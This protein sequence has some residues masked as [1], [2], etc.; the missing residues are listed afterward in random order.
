MASTR[1]IETQHQLLGLLLATILGVQKE[2]D[3]DDGD[4]L[5]VT[6]PKN[7]KQLLNTESIEQLLCQFV[8]WHSSR[9]FNDQCY[10]EQD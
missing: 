5:R 2:D 10:R 1:S 8:A 3:N 4:D 7:A 6:I 9:K